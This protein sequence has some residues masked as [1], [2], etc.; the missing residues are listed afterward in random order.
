MEKVLEKPLLHYDGSLS[1]FR[2]G[3]VAVKITKFSP[4]ASEIQEVKK[5]AKVTEWVSNGALESVLPEKVQP[6][7]LKLA[8]S[9]HSRGG[10]T[11]FSLA[12]GYGDLSSSTPTPIKFQALLGIDPVAGSSPSSQSAPKILQY[13]PR[14][15]DQTVPVAVIGAG[16]SNQRAHYIFPPFAPNGV[17][18]S[19][20]FNECK[21]PCYY[22]LA[23]DY[24]HT[25]ILDDK[26]AAIASLVAK[27]GKGSKDLMRKAVGGIVVA[28]L[29]AKLGGK[30]DN[31]NAIVQE[32]SLAPITLDPVI[33]VK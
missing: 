27:S 5:A 3:D 20:F 1:V 31:L 25:D 21:P 30:V 26:I 33:S 32:P 28:F 29:E 13:I 18:H 11:A 24:G 6:D 10:K 8:V 19:E 7:L 14:N 16:L 4:V 9:G 12:L 2:E 22:F 17:N 15:F 23:K